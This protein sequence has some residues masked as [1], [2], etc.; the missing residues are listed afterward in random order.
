MSLAIDIDKITEVLLV[1]GWHKVA[2]NKQGIS[3]FDL[4][5]YEYIQQRGEHKDP[6]LL[7]PG[8]NEQLVPATGFNFAESGG[9]IIYGPVTAILAVRTGKLSTRR[10]SREDGIR[11]PV[12]RLTKTYPP[13]VAS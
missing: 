4:D 12:G 13:K 7:L 6:L 5:A 2:M 11:P 8:G 1:D 10:V 9:S 3:T